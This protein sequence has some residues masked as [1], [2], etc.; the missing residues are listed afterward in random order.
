[1]VVSSPNIPETLFEAELFG[2]KKGAYT[3]AVE[4][5]GLAEEATNGTLFFD[6]ISEIPV[7]LQAKLLRFIETGYYRKLGEEREKKVN[8]HIIC[9]SNKNLEEEV[10]NGRF[11]KDLYFRISAYVIEIPPLRERPEDIV[12]IAKV[13][14]RRNGYKITERGLEFLKA[15]NFPG[16]VRELQ[17]LLNRAMVESEARVIDESL[18]KELSEKASSESL[19]VENI[20]KRLKSGESFW[21]VVKKPFMNRELS[22]EKVKKLIKLG[23][24]EAGSYKKLCEIF[25]IELD[26]YHNFMTFL[27]KH[28]LIDKKK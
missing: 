9:A 21:E 14:V 28:K 15:L 2:C 7:T 24:A 4:R 18:L 12:E 11:R 20:M 17:N 25:N 5:K 13:Y 19:S 16:N 22:R 6:E 8:T 27:H 23:L 10:K 3:G 26:R 1:M